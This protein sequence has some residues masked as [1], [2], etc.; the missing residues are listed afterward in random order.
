VSILI[1]GCNGKIFE[2]TTEGSQGPSKPKP[3]PVAQPVKAVLAGPDTEFMQRM[4]HDINHAAGL[5]DVEESLDW[6]AKGIGRLTNDE[7]CVNLALSTGFSDIPVKLTLASNDT[8]DTLDRLVTAFERIADSVAKLA[9]LSRPRLETWQ[10]QDGY[11]PRHK[12]AAADGGAPGPK[13]Q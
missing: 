5:A 8:D 7:A 3:Q 2:A 1:G 13:A 6:I 4:Q 11:E 10:E 12:A 9:G